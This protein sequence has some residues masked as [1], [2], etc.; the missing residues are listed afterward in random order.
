MCPPGAD[1]AISDAIVTLLSHAGAKITRIKD[2]PG[3][4][5]QRVIAMIGNLSQVRLEALI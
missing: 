1:P 2:S 3:F 5:A 4:V